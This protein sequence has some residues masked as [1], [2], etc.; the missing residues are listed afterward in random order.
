MTLLQLLD[1][2]GPVGVPLSMEDVTDIRNMSDE[3]LLERSLKEVDLFEIL[4]S[5]YQKQ[6]LERAFFV[7]KDRDDA[8]DIVQDTFV[9]I[10]RFAP[11]FRGESGTF[12]AWATTILMNVARTRYQKKAKQWKRTAP[13][14]QEHYESLGE[15]SKEDARM[16]KDEIERALTLVSDDVA[17]ILRLAFLE[18]LSYKEIAERE[19]VSE[20]AIKTRVHRAKKILRATIEK[21]R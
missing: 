6:F 15:E 7:V 19:G 4:V 1:I 13:L 5:R 20:G 11:R 2:A 9:R 21:G 16:A 14:T 10:Y 8:E 17:Y 18:D 12:K 3:A